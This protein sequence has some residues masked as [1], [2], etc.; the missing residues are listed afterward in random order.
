MVD[1]AEHYDA[2]EFG[3]G[4]VGDARMEDEDTYHIDQNTARFESMMASGVS[5]QACVLRTHVAAMLGGHIFVR[6]LD[7]HDDRQ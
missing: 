7:Q 6:L 3:L 4:I 1:F 5:G 2:R